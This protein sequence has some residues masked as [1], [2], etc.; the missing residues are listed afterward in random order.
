VRPVRTADSNLVYVG[1]T[2]DVGDLHC[3]RIRPGFIRSVWSFSPAERE[4]IAQGATL[5]LEI[6]TEPIPP[7][8]M[9]IGWEQGVG[10][11]DS[12]VRRR[13]AE[14]GQLRLGDEP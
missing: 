7:V 12:D 9:A 1:P 8:G 10:E 4:A 2:L 5:A 13:M 11:D 3:Q 14:L 6:Y